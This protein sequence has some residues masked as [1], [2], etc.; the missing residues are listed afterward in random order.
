MQTNDFKLSE[1]GYVLPANFDEE[2]AKIKINKAK[3]WTLVGTFTSF[4]VQKEID[5]ALTAGVK[6][7]RIGINVVW[8][9]KSLLDFNNWLK[10]PAG[11]AAVSLCRHEE[12]ARKAGGYKLG[13]DDH[14]RLA[15]A[16]VIQARY[17]SEKAS[18][19]E[20]IQASITQKLR[21]LG[22]LRK[23]LDDAEAG[24]R[25]KYAPVS[26]AVPV[27]PLVLSEECFNLAASRAREEDPQRVIPATDDEFKLAVTAYGQEV[28]RAHL[29]A[30]LATPENA[31]ALNDLAANVIQ[32]MGRSG[33]AAPSGFSAAATLLARGGVAEAV[34]ASSSSSA[35]MV[36]DGVAAEELPSSSSSSAAAASSSSS[37]AAVARGRPSARRRVG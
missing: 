12:A 33:A 15:I 26:T 16:A 18:V 3:Y 7:G 10:S 31:A 19:I 9:P 28:T 30:H 20:P 37:S 4:V 36:D 25:R 35:A 24:V 8:T 22:R 34:G 23:E 5:I 17:T 29:A 1:N 21:E 13:G 27:D 32:D 6:A 2:L 11:A 14:H